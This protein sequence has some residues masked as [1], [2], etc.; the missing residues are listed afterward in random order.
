MVIK[1]GFRMRTVG[2]DHIVI[3]EGKQLVSFNKMASL[4]PTAAYLWEHIQGMEFETNDIVRLL[5]EKYDI[6][7]QTAAADAAKFVNAL[8]EAGII[9]Q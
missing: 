9:G 6:D 2:K 7:E 5:C 4:N 8:A 3:P 1:E